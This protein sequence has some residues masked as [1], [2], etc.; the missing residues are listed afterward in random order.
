MVRPRPRRAVFAASVSRL[1]SFGVVPCRIVLLSDLAMFS[2]VFLRFSHCS[3]AALFWVAPFVF[4]SSLSWVLTKSLNL[5]GG[6]VYARF[7]RYV[8]PG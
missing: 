2:M 6:M 3:H 5:L 7:S 8:H 1:V 4:D